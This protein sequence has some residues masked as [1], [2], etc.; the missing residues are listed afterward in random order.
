MLSRAVQRN[1]AARSTRS[2]QWEPRPS[3][4]SGKRAT[5]PV[6]VSSFAWLLTIAF[7]VPDRRPYI[8]A[9][10]SS[11]LAH[12]LQQAREV[13]TIH[14]R[15]A[16]GEPVHGVVPVAGEVIGRPRILVHLLQDAPQVPEQEGHGFLKDNPA[17][18]VG[19]RLLA[20]V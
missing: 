7:I 20:D 5:L 9:C 19:L 13:F 2:C 12:R 6:M 1:A 3:C 8:K 4:L 11:A 14:D 10:R 15:L 18:L 17:F 16:P